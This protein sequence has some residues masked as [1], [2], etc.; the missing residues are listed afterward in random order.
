MVVA[1]FIALLAA[2]GGEE[3]VI[4]LMIP[5][6]SGQATPL[7]GIRLVLLP[8]DRDS[9]LGALERQA[10]SPRPDQRRLDSLAARFRGPFNELLRLTAAAD[11]GGEAGTAAAESLPRARAALDRARSALQPAIDSERARLRTWE[12]TAFRAYDSVGATLV[13]ARRRDP[14]VDSTRAGGTV[15]LALPGGPWWVVARAVNVQDPNA[16]WYWNVAVA[17]DTV[18]LSPENAVSRLR[19]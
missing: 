14:V 12:D 7:P 19:R 5:D 18:R 6:Q 10:G 4:Q 2:C 8:Y 16:E 3:V 17:G 15:T 11:R 13:R 1:G 9:V